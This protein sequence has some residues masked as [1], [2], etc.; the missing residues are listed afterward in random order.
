MKKSERKTK[1][2]S[3]EIMRIIANLLI[4]RILGETIA[5]KLKLGTQTDT[6]LLDGKE[7]VNYYGR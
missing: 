5:E 2:D 6:L 1:K 4:D 3:D 7:T